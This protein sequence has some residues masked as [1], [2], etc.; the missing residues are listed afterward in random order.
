VPIWI[1]DYVLMGY[2]TG[3]VF[4][5]PAHDERDHG[6]AKRFDLP[7]IEVVKGGNVDEAAWVED[8]PHVNSEFM[9]GLNV[10][11]AKKKIVEWLEA[12]GH[13]GF[14]V[15]YRLRD[16]LFSRQRYWGEPFPIVHTEDGEVIP[17]PEDR[18]PVELPHLDEFLA[19]EDGRPPLARDPGWVNTTVPG[20]ERPA[21]RE[22]NT[23]PQ[24]AGSCWYYLRFIDPRN[25]N[26]FVDPA[27]EKRW[28]P[29]DLYVGGAEHAV[30]HLL[31]ARF[32]HKV[33]F[34]LGLVSTPE[35]F[36]K[37]VNQGMITARSF[38]SAAGK[39][40]YP[41]DVEKRGDDYYAKDGAGP[42]ETQIEK[43]SKSRYNVT[44]PDQVI[45]NHG[46]DSLRL[47]ETFIG[48]VEENAE[49]QTEN[50]PG[51]R[52]F[53]DRTWRLL[54]PD[55][56][57]G[58]RF[59]EDLE[60]DD[61]LDRLLH[62][63]VKKVTED[64]E[65]MHM[66]TAVSQL[67]I[68][69]NEATQRDVLPRSVL[70]TVIRLLSP[71]APHIAEEMWHRMGHTESVSRAPWPE[72]D[73]A[74]TLDDQIDVPVQVNGKLRSVIQLARGTARDEA[75]A[76]A[77]DDAKVTANLEGKTVVK[78]IVVPDKLINFVVKP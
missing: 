44:T 50:I 28:M 23:M 4:A 45:E 43:M 76:A 70:E 5:C 41:E 48:P 67:M 36:M 62:K 7:I 68:F 29:V 6:F 40:Y 47:Y 22:T 60:P 38:R 33:L 27:A 63:T 49:W 30:L 66:N 12:H 20:S 77:R 75:E 72:Y 17:V 34:D 11:E 53:L 9:D 8:G 1:A 51:V 56:R 71:F 3:A 55:E 39:Y 10:A 42:L 78:V 32:W 65:G 31:Y 24:W 35:P 69:V 18:L 15:Q 14:E 21:V 54:F 57:E 25:P 52:R 64:I 19:T 2:G 16:W 13:G 73:E 58:P 37:L 74:K 59:A 46:A 26:A 61:R